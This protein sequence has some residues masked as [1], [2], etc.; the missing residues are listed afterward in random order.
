[1]IFHDSKVKTMM[2]MSS[3]TGWSKTE[4]KKRRKDER[5]RMGGSERREEEG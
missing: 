4:K 5:E 2:I 1:M 3:P